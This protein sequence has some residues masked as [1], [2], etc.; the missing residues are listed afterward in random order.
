LSADRPPGQEAGQANLKETVAVLSRTV[1]MLEQDK[2]HL[3]QDVDNLALQHEA[4]VR[5]LQDAHAADLKQAI[6][7]PS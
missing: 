3:E 2:R 1:Q 7:R 5:S 4:K 6:R